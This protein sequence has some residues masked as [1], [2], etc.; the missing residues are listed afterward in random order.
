MKNRK[1]FRAQHILIE[2]LDDALYILEKLNLGATFEDLA[3][4]FS[5]CETSSKGGKL[6]TFFS[7]EM[8]PEFEK[9]L[10][11]LSYGEVSDPVKTKFGFHII[12]NIDKNS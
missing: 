2:D 7:G 5:E 12:K 11:T 8:D 10:S 4:E 1:S 3:H 6:G 9:A